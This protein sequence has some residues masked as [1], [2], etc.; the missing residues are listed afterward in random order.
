MTSRREPTAGRAIPHR[1]DPDARTDVRSRDADHARGLISAVF[2]AHAL[3]V[4][5]PSTE[6]DMVL[7]ARRTDSI[8]IAELR[9]GTEVVVRPERLKS[10][11]EINVPL[12]GHSV[13]IIG[14]RQVTAEPGQAVV[15]PPTE[16]VTMRWS[17][18]CAQ[19]AV[20]ISRAAVERTLEAVLGHPLDETVRFGLRFDVTD[21][22]G[23]GWLR[24]VDLLRQALDDGAPEVV[25][26]P[27]EDLIVAQLLVGQPHNFTGRFDGR[28]RPPRPR[29]LARVLELI[30]GDPAAPLTLTDMA[31]VAGTSVR[32]VQAAFTEH[33]DMSPMSYLRHIRLARAHED[34]QAAVPGDGQTV[35]DIALRWGFGHVPRF[36][37]AYRERYGV[38]P[39][40]TL[41]G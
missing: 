12:R 22:P 9:H 27:L 7:R 29:M 20:K 41:R 18:D 34:L 5:G 31:R 11:Y 28:S 23:Q 10:Y 4:V 13:T 3:E 33:L 1:R 15:L 19:M 6:L 17:A 37:A 21:G 2:S 25:T 26:R 30:E 39:S 8:T 32:S 35:T 14:D 40:Q 36:A 38:S 24:A 16:P